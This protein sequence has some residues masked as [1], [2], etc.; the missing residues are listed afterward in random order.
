MKL[1]I[2]FLF[3]VLLLASAQAQDFR[4]GI[5]GGANL[6]NMK[7]E[8]EFFDDFNIDYDS[9]NR[10]GWQVGLVL[11]TPLTNILTFQPAILL[12]K[13]GY[14]FEENNIIFDIETKSKP[15]YL[16]VP[17]PALIKAEVGEFAIFAG[18]GPYVSFGI[19]GGIDSEGDVLTFDFADDGDIEWGNDDDDTYRRLDA[20]AVL[21]G[22]VEVSGIQ[23]ALTYEHGLANIQPDGDDDNFVRNRT[24]SLTATLFL[25]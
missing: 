18:A 12:S 19:G 10:L 21:T 16:H 7:I 6:A 2:T 11:E 5:R 17:L 15:L 8:N 25:D 3:P 23:L 24:L 22:G 9:E 4:I 20:G 13:K 1:L 14:R